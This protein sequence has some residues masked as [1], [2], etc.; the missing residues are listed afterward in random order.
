[1]HTFFSHGGHLV[2]SV[3]GGGVFCTPGS[4]TCACKYYTYRESV[5]HYRVDTKVLRVLVTPPAQGEGGLGTAISNHWTAR[6]QNW[7][8]SCG[9]RQP[10][11]IPT[12]RSV[13]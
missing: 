9:P 4:P 5:K 8:G 3:S 13:T 10:R 12:S 6:T 1:M 2:G 11:I 7:E